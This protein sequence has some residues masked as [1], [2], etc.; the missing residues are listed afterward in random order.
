M[1]GR[2]PKLDKLVT[3]GPLLVHFFDFAQLNSVRA[4]DY[5]REWRGRYREHGLAVLGIH[6]P[7]TAMTRPGPAVEAALPRLGIDWPV[8]LDTDLRVFRDYGVLGWPSLFL[9]GRGGALRWHHVGEGEYRATE[10]SIREQLGDR[11]NGGWPDLLE[12]IRPGDGAS[13][14]VTA[15]PPSCSP[16]RPRA[17]PGRGPASS[18]SNTPLPGRSR[19]RPAAERWRSAS[20]AVRPPR[21]RWTG[22]ASTSSR[23][24][25]GTVSTGS[26]C[27]LR[28]G[29][30]STPFSSLRASG[31]DAYGTRQRRS[32]LG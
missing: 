2:E 12:P 24:A 5:V 23:R 22:P 11:S 17:S 28:P 14:E 3:V 4:M 18:R 7:R 6:S 1:G 10:E 26:T 8:A 15:P 32:G 19:P 25:S 31:L 30:R 21:W 27:G 16:G 13:D 20:T 9:W 29:S